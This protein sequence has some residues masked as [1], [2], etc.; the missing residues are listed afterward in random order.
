MNRLFKLASVV[1]ILL[2]IDITIMVMS[3]DKIANAAIES[4]STYAL[5]VKMTVND[6]DVGNLSGALSLADLHVPIRPVMAVRIF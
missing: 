1:V 6:V 5:G 4:G 2:I 3:I